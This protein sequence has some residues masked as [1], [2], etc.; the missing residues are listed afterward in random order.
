MTFEMH[1]MKKLIHYRADDFIG[2]KRPSSGVRKLNQAVRDL[3]EQDKELVLKLIADSRVRFDLL[4]GG[5]LPIDPLTVWTDFDQARDY[6]NLGSEHLPPWKQLSEFLKMHVLFQAVLTFGGYAFTARVRPDLQARWTAN[7]VNPMQR[8]N[9]LLKRE[10]DGLGLH[11]LAHCYVLEGRTRSGKSKTGLHLHG[12]M[13]CDDRTAVKYKVAL[14]RAFA[15]HPKGRA[16]AGIPRG[17][18]REVVIERAYDIRDPDD[19]RGGVWVSYMAKNATKPD[20]RMSGKRTY[21]SREATGLARDFWAL[22]REEPL[23]TDLQLT[24]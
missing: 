7:G 20:L 10:L 15:C 24:A 18:G 11:S 12:F 22:I 17:S 5:R 1:S 19:A 8:I 4:G 23:E 3:V 21:M 9:R 14:E 6:T 16:A 2:A 13:L